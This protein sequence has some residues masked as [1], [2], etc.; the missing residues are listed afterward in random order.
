M[1]MTVDRGADHAS[2][3][4]KT[5]IFV[6]D[7]NLSAF[8]NTYINAF[9]DIGSDPFYLLYHNADKYDL[10]ITEYDPEIYPDG[11]LDA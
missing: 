7:E 3:D 5:G 1:K 10:T 6:G 8:L 9:I 2:Y 4:E 11:T